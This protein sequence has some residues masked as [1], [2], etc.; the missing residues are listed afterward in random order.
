VGFT[1]VQ[2]ALHATTAN[3]GSIA[4]A[5][6][7]IGAGNVLA[8]Y[9]KYEGD[10]INITVSDGT[11]TFAEGTQGNHSNNDLG[12]QWFYLLSANSGN[13]TITATFDANRPF[14]SIIIFEFSHTDT[15][16]FDAE[17]GSSGTSGGAGV[18]SSGDLTTAGA[19][20][21]LGG[22]SEY[23]SLVTDTERC[24]DVAAD[25]VVRTSSVANFT[26][27]W[28]KIF[29]GAI[30]GDA[31]CNLPGASAWLLRAIAFKDV[32]PSVD[33]VARPIPRRHYVFDA[34]QLY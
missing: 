16:S 8:A 26:V 5:M 25:G 3:N 34:R 31:D 27:A 22:Y 10:D 33:K 19:A 23:S 4:K 30:T 9:V 17:A 18:I 6:T 1:F 14:K 12:G 2:S 13:K 24:D 32:A 20:V 28:Y 15:A 29:S 7:G 11:S 21:M